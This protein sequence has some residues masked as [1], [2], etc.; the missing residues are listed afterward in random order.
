[1]ENR[2]KIE[3]LYDSRKKSKLIAYAIGAVLGSLGG[4]YFYLGKENYGCVILGLL[5][6]STVVPQLTIVFLLAVF[7]GVIHTA[8]VCDEVNLQIRDECQILME[9]D[10]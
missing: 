5:V 9:D 4:H 2:L 1:M 8:F 6:V 10:K 7:A 3:V